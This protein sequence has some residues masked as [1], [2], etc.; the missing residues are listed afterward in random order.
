VTKP[1]YNSPNSLVPLHVVK[2]SLFHFILKNLTLCCVANFSPHFFVN[3]FM[4]YTLCT[5]LVF[6]MQLKLNYEMNTRMFLFF[7]LPRIIFV[8][9]VPFA[10]T[11]KITSKLL[12][13]LVII[14][15]RFTRKSL[16]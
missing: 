9:K 8:Q 6:V 14:T 10:S 12:F 11:P 16:P 7:L 13:F 4:Y 1:A 5:S 15:A 3:F 2:H